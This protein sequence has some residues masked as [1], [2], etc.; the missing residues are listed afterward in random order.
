ML[1]MV[2]PLDEICSQS[3][4]DYEA[5]GRSMVAES[6]V[7]NPCQG[8]K[9]VDIN[10]AGLDLDKSCSAAQRLLQMGTRPC[11]SLTTVSSSRRVRPA[12]S[13]HKTRRRTSLL[14]K[15][16]NFGI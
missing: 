2:D 6:P 14:Q 11:C 12:L 9:L 4:V 8:K 1:Y 13:G 3:I 5:S 15:G 10:K 7:R 16:H